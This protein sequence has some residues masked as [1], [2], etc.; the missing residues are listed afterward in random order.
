MPHVT[1]LTFTCD[2]QMFLSKA[3]KRDRLL[4]RMVIIDLRVCHIARQN[5]MVSHSAVISSERSHQLK[6][7][8]NYKCCPV[9]QLI[10]R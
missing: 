9:S 5:G 10:V 8:M 3:F 7:R 2:K 6:H 1:I 4:P